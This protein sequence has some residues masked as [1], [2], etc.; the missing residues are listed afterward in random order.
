MGA[1][2][3]ACRE[4]VDSTRR[5]SP[6]TALEA[7]GQPGPKEVEII[8]SADIALKPQPRRA[9]KDPV[10]VMFVA[11]LCPPGIAREFVIRGFPHWLIS[12]IEYKP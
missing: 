2:R 4:T 12:I 7:R 10:F 6:L 1:W 9:T 3:L 5:L 11:P 8:A